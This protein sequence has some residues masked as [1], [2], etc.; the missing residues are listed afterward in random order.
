MRNYPDQIR[1]LK[2]TPQA[3]VAMIIWADEYGPFDGGS[4]DFW[5]RLSPERKRRCDLVVKALSTD[6]AKEKG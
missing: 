3:R 1:N 2:P 4:M 5:D 6:A